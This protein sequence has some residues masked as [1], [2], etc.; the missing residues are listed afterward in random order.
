MG[1]LEM[2]ISAG[3]LIL[4][5]AVLRG[6]KLWLL[7]KRAVMLL[8][9]VVLARL[10]LPGSL[11][12][13]NGIAAPVFYLLWRIGVLPTDV[14]K[15]AGAGTALQTVQKAA[16]F[17]TADLSNSTLL[18]Q[19]AEFV[20][21]AGLAGTGVYFAYL[22]WKEHRL[23]AEAL[24]LAFSS[25]KAPDSQV[26]EAYQTA[27]RL[28]GRSLQKKSIQI[29][30]HDRIQSPLV[31]GILRQRIVIPKE[32]LD[33]GKAQMQHILLHEMV[34]IRRHDNLWKLL[35][36]AAL[37]IHWFNPAVWL[38]VLLFVRDMELSC[39]ERVLS[40]YGSQGRQEYAMTLLEL[41]Q[42]Q[43]GTAL[44]C[45][46]FLENPVKER[47]VSIMKYKKLTG[48]GMLCTVM[49]LA[50]ATSVFATNEQNANKQEQ[51]VPYQDAQDGQ[52]ADTESVFVTQTSTVDGKTKIDKKGPASI[53]KDDNQEKIVVSFNKG[54]DT[55]EK[56]EIV[57]RAEPSEDGSSPH[58]YYEDED[59]KIYC[60]SYNIEEDGNIR[61]VPGEKVSKPEPEERPH[62]DAEKMNAASASAG[63]MNAASASAGNDET[64]SANMQTV[65]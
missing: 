4:L 10:L 1:L 13:Q 12:I 49:L 47:I 36:A 25:E 14:N 41:A 38:M 27:S 55:N 40:M 20:W 16:S 64:Y 46:G 61:L 17:S 53:V 3:V 18:A 60:Y 6:G 39:D 51:E 33:L 26:L 65:Q 5:V 32:L 34:H 8:W 29:L 45:S 44:F 37:C 2:S 59:G 54:I 23:L 52:D 15:A 48:I 58:Y 7:T 30:V 19:L 56:E 57:L 35:A 28:S 24:P 22:F 63:Q 62:S 42:N 43:R 50:G 9:M 11:P 21:L 31:F